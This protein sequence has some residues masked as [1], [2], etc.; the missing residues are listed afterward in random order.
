[1]A[2][3]QN[4]QVEEQATEVPATEKLTNSLMESFLK[5]D[6]VGNGSA[7]QSNEGQPA[8]EQESVVTEE[9][10]APKEEEEI[11][12]PN[13]FIKNKWG[14]E[15]EEVA[16]NEIKALR[17]KAEKAEKGFE[18]KNDE[19]KKIAE[20]IN[21][22]KID[23]LYSFLDTQKRVEKLATADL[24][25]KNVAAEL[26]KFGIQK[27]NPNL[28]ADE[29][30]FLF[31]K[32]FATPKEPVQKIDE[33]DTEF[34]ERVEDWKQHKA[35]IERELVIEAKMAQPKLAQYKTELVLP[36]IR[37]EVPQTNQPTAEELQVAEKFRGDY[38]QSVEK[39]VA[40]LSG[41]SL[42]VK[43]KDV[44]I[45][46]SYSFT[47]QEKNAVK[48]RMDDFAANGYNAT[49]I[50]ADLWVT[51]K[52]EVDTDKMSKDLAYLLFKDNINQK[53]ATDAAN[54][55]LD[56]F[57]KEKKQID[58]TGTRPQGQFNPSAPKTEQ[59]AVTESWLAV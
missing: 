56:A 32:K 45:P 14:W 40:N 43:D 12:D 11:L 55:R 27:D 23:E 31:N 8:Q 25:D 6:F 47:Q 30:D 29:I 36:D 53:I 17:E 7:N 20:Y 16:D 19:S 41:I 39:S 26:V 21:E 13:T 5:D 10:T 46:L 22:G 58:V 44:E 15:S 48:Q 34:E 3:E 33:T 42:T 4:V 24:S 49:A 28:N 38:L 37:K 35:N 52:G 59:E 57:F 9:V 1:M 2:D 50:L 54:K 51:P 18:Y